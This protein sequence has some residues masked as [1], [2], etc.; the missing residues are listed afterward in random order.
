MCRPRGQIS[1][2]LCGT[3][4]PGDYVRTELRDVEGRDGKLT[5]ALRMEVSAKDHALKAPGLGN[6]QRQGAG[7]RFKNTSDDHA[8]GGT[9]TSST[10]GRG[11]TPSGGATTEPASK[12]SA[13]GE[14]R[15]S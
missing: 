12:S 15:R 1:S 2:T 3:N 13:V 9:G 10:P 4:A 6:L 7:A 5:R 14:R 8:A 11:T